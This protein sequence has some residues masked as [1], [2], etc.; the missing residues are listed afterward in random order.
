M[1]I[2]E[3]LLGA[4]ADVHAR[5][6]G[7]T[8]LHIAAGK[9][10]LELAQLLLDHGADINALATVRGASVTPLALAEQSKQEKMAALL[11]QRGGRS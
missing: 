11:K 4:G 8:S 1:D 5:S 10:Y 7:Q 9:G 2:A 6:L 3:F